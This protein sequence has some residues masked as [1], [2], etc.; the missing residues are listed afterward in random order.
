MK[1]TLLILLIAFLGFSLFAYNAQTIFPVGSPVY[2]WIKALYIAEGYSLPSTSGPWSAAELGKMLEK[3]DEPGLPVNMKALY[4]QACDAVHE[5]EERS[6]FNLNFDLFVEAY[7]H[8]NTGSYLGRDAWIRGWDEMKPFFRFSTDAYVGTPFYG[9]FEFTLGNSKTFTVSGN[10]YTRPWGSSSFNSNLPMVPPNDMKQLDFNM[11]YRAFVAAGSDVISFQMGRDNLSWGAGTTGNL[12]IGDQLGYHNLFRVAAFTKSFKWTFLL[13]F[14]PHPQNYYDSTGYLPGGTGGGQSQYINGIRFFMGH[15]LEW[16]MLSD[17]MTFTL[18]EGVMYMSKDNRLDLI[19]L[20]PSML[21]HNNYTRSL[22]NSILGLELDCTPIKG[23]NL[24]VSMVIDESVLPG[25]P[26]PESTTAG[27][28]AEPNGRG[29]IAGATYILNAKQGYF[30]FNA[31]GAYTDP[32]LYLRDGDLQ[33]GSASRTQQK[34]EYGINYVVAVREQADCGGTTIYDE[35]FLGYQ[36]GG[37][38]IVAS[39]NAGYA[40]AGSFDVSVNLFYMLHGTHDQWTVWTRIDN[41]AGRMNQA[42]PTTNHQTENQ[43]DDDVSD[44]NSVEKTFVAGINGSF[45][46]LKG[47]K[48]YGQLDFVSKINPDNDST[49]APEHDLQLTIGSSY[50]F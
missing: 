18:T 21:Y 36:H 43:N 22:T 28:L 6:D 13:S 24:Y 47:L 19:V 32:Y 31:E 2:D 39:L 29:F 8:T 41:T 4:K 40:K 23:L 9:Y 48:V 45:N 50:S 44:R 30:H 12:I 7:L 11:P 49:R 26:N 17:K 35:Q 5:T 33:S 42:S 20:N 3:I 37:D 38:A 46:V 14:F 27:N 34:G 15:R 1:K 25:E 10:P 16:R